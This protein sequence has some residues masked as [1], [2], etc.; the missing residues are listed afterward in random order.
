MVCD[1]LEG[2]GT[3]TLNGAITCHG[4]TFKGAVRIEMQGMEM[5]QQ[6]SGR[7]IGKFQE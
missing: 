3:S 6:M 2:E 1:T 7:P 4:E 5:L